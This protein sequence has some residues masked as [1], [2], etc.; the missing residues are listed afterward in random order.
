MIPEFVQAIEDTVYDILYNEVHTM[1]PAVVV[2]Y[3]SKKGV[4][5]AD[6]V[7]TYYLADSDVC[8]EYPRVYDVPVVFPMT[9]AG[10]G[11][12]FP[13]KKGDYGLLIISETDI[14]EW[15][16]G[17]ESDGEMHYDLASGI[18]IPGLLQKGN[19]LTE[20]ATLHDAV[21]LKHGSNMVAVNKSEV[22]ITAPSIKIN[23]N[24]KVSG[25]LNSGSISSSGSISA[26]G[27]VHGSNI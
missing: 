21:V 20:Y 18:F 23:G 8:M 5:E 11:F 12:A 22:T 14:E 17:S 6:P 26:S 24:L 15:R 9:S 25:T 10:V 19:S 1:I 3:D 13:V 2:S 16:T 4:V 7:G 27:S